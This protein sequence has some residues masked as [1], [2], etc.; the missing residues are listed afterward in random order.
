M[1][2]V[3]PSGILVQG[4]FVIEDQNGNI[5]G[6]KNGPQKMVYYPLWKGIDEY[7]AEQIKRIEAEDGKG[8]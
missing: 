1:R 6:H 2:T 4:V 5:V 7:I 8:T 3:K